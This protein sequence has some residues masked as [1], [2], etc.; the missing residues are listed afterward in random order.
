MR[1]HIRLMYQQQPPNR[2]RKPKATRPEKV[3][4][5]RKCQFPVRFNVRSGKKYLI[6]I[7]KLG[8]ARYV[9]VA[10]PQSWTKEIKRMS[11]KLLCKS[12][13]EFIFAFIEVSCQS[14]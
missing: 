8:P 4:D 3:V 1:K 14:F 9:A 5:S 11:R 10:Q 12:C 7:R 13:G 2:K 6:F